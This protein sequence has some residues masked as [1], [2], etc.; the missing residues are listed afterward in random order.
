MHAAFPPLAFTAAFSER[1]A[2]LYFGFGENVKL[3]MWTRDNQRPMTSRQ[4]GEQTRACV[5]H[6]PRL[7]A[8]ARRDRAGQCAPFTAAKKDIA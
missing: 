2:K 8:Q 6:V 5:A 3:I 1:Q 4:K 7:Y